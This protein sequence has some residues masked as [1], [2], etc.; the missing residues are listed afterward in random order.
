M[1]RNTQS[2]LLHCLWSYKVTVYEKDTGTKC[3]ISI[4]T[5]KIRKD[6]TVFP[7]Y[8]C[9]YSSQRHTV[10]VSQL[11]SYVKVH[12]LSLCAATLMEAGEMCTAMWLLVTYR[13]SVY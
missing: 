6:K 12:R 13:A 10:H 3:K 11:L 2:T 7:Q 8:T 5:M 1:Q 9:Q 4:V